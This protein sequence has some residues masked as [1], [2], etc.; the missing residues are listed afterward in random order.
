VIHK[1][2]LP[3]RRNKSLSMEPIIPLNNGIGRK[4]KG[5]L[6][7][8]GD[9]NQ[10]SPKLQPTPLKYNRKTSALIELKDPPYVMQNL[11]NNRKT[12]REIEYKLRRRHGGI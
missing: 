5:S 4:I 11:I 9:T 1:E 6:D 12:S 7:L 10:V 2:K 8:K 3:A